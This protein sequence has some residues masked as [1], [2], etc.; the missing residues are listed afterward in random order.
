MDWKTI[1]A[2]LESV[3]GVTRQQLAEIAGLSASAIQELAN[4]NTKQP[5]YEAGVRLMAMHKIHVRPEQA[6]AA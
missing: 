1:I 3:P 4:G 5:G 2:E 6:D